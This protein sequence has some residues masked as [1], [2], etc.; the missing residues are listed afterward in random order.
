MAPEIRLSLH[1]SQRKASFG[2]KNRKHFWRWYYGPLSLLTNFIQSILYFDDY[3]CPRVAFYIVQVLEHDSTIMLSE[4]RLVFIN[5]TADVRTII[6]TSITWPQSNYRMELL[7]HGIMLFKVASE[8]QAI[9]SESLAWNKHV[10]LPVWARLR[11][12]HR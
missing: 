1:Y 6:N 5:T 8:S 3:I 12:F 10:C 4:K 2:R 11:Y 9:L 7:P